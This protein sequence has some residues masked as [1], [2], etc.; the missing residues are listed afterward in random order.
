MEGRPLGDGEW[1]TLAA[2]RQGHN[3][4]LRVDGGDGRSFTNHSLDSFALL[5][6][7]ARGGRGDEQ[8]GKG[9]GRRPKNLTYPALPPFLHVDKHDGV[10]VGGWPEFEAG[11]LVRVHHDLTE[12]KSCLSPS[13]LPSLPLPYP[14]LCPSPS[15]FQPLFSPPCPYLCLSPFASPSSPVLPTPPLTLSLCFQAAST[16]CGY[17]GGRCLCRPRSTAAGGAR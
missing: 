9:G 13:F 11:R 4:L 15:P 12:S 7:D 2:E 14:Y 8:R 1:H 6:W 17:Q 3:L 10:T 16:I 5:S